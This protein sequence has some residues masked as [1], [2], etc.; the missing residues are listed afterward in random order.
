MKHLTLFL[1][2]IML[3]ILACGSP[4]EDPTPEPTAE[5]PEPTAE[6][7]EPEVE[8]TAPPQEPEEVSSGAVNDLQQVQSAIIQIQAEGSFVD[9]EFGLQLNSAGRGSGFIIDPSGIAVTNNHVVTGSALLR[10]WVG[11]ET[12]PRNA[13]ILGVSECSDLAVIDI[14]GE[15]YPYLEW[16]PGAPTV[17]TDLYV[18]GFPLGDPEFTLT[19]GIVSKANADGETPWSSVDSV[20]EYDATTNPGNSGGPVVDNAAKVLAVHYAGNSGTR[21]AYGIGSD[22]ASIVV[23]RLRQGENVDSIGIN[24]TAVTDGEGLSGVWV[25]SVESGSPADV[26]GIRGGDVLTALEGFI[27]STDGTMA[28]YCDILRSHLP[29]DTL[30]VQVVRYSTQE[31]LEGQLNGRVLEPSFSFAQELN[32]D[33]GQVAD[34]G[35]GQPAA[36]YSQYVAVSDETNSLTVEVPAEWNQVDGSQWLVDGEPIGWQVTAAPD[37]NGFNTTWTTPGVFFGASIVLADYTEPELL[38]FFDYSD[39]C[40]YGGREAYEDALYSGVYDVWSEC[41]GTNSMYVVVSAS[42]ESQA[43]IILVGVQVVTEADLAALDQIL[44]TFIVNE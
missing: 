9:P 10:V 30:N 39:S 27:L 41:G 19:R 6:P 29:T 38:D 43:Y 4:G 40:S 25:S 13:R 18:A 26:A 33:A 35:S 37:L 5:L 22:L 32:D 42:P 31:V 23:D 36:G 3:S 8:E 14:D 7:T 1:V 17:G 34:D 11:G 44:N 20:I 24:G 28:D 21:Q 12:E 16:Y 15:G 2:L